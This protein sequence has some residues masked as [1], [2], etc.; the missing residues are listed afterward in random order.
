MQ[1]SSWAGLAA[2]Q[3][4]SWGI[5]FPPCWGAKDAQ[6]LSSRAASSPPS[7]AKYCTLALAYYCTVRAHSRIDIDYG[8]MHQDAHSEMGGWGL[9]G[10]IRDPDRE[11]SIAWWRIECVMIL[12]RDAGATHTHGHLLTMHVPHSRVPGDPISASFREMPA[13]RARCHEKP[14]AASHRLNGSGKSLPVLPSR[15]LRQWPRPPTAMDR[16]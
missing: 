8:T 3:A 15:S 5:A 13:C 11:C 14:I 9:G 2:K 16:E 12:Y 7:L 10:A 1:A 4:S 6:E